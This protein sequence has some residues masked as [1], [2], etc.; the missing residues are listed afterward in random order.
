MPL[1]LILTLTLTGLCRCTR[2]FCTT[3]FVTALAVEDI[4]IRIERRVIVR[5][6]RR[7]IERVTRRVT[8]RVKG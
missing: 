6:T 7:V 8:R 4:T 1:T 3:Q 2:T 5:V